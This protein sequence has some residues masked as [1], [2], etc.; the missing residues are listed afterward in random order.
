MILQKNSLKNAPSLN[1]SKQ[2]I[3]SLFLPN[4]IIGFPDFKNVD[5]VYSKKELPFMR[6]QEKKPQGIEFFVLEPYDLFP[7]YKIEISEPDTES[8]AISSK[9]EAYIVNVVTFPANTSASPTANLVAPIVFNRKK[10]IG[11]QCIILNFNTY[12]PRHNLLNN[13]G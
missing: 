9:E 4:G 11:K 1:P 2:L 5:L 3:P 13:L 12:S 10:F 7:D 6:L 8:L